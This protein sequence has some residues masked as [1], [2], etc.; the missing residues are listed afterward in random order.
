MSTGP[1]YTAP[2][3]RG[4][5]LLHLEPGYL[6]ARHY[7]GYADEISRR[8]REHRALGA[9]SSPLVAAAIRAGSH[10]H[11]ARVWPGGTRTLERRLK[12]GGGLSRHCP[13]CR[14]TGR[15]HR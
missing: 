3:G 15:Y 4:L 10:V 14:A 6:H 9:R 1:A 7:L 12:R 8:V 2:S 5:Y 13:V 11:L